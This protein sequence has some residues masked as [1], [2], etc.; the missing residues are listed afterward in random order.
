MGGSCAMSW[1]TSASWANSVDVGDRRDHRIPPHTPPALAKAVDILFLHQKLVAACPMSL[2][3]SFSPPYHYVDSDAF[4]SDSMQL[5]AFPESSK[6]VVLTCPSPVEPRTPTNWCP[7]SSTHHS[8]ASHA[9]RPH[10]CVPGIAVGLHLVRLSRDL[11]PQCPWLA[12]RCSIGGHVYTSDAFITPRAAEHG[13]QTSW[14]GN[15]E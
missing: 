3:S 1:L 10:D 12:K 4:L 6:S 2:T 5:D 11:D 15:P 9:S 8:A 14:R 7:W 13:G